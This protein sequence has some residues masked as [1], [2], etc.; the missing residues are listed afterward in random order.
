M[1]N[2]REMLRGSASYD[3]D[4][5]ARAEVWSNRADFDKRVKDFGAHAAT[6]AQLVSQ[7][8]GN[9]DAFKNAARAVAQDCKGCH[10][11]YQSK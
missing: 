1:K 2:A 11:T 6:L 9:T 4:T 3:G 8:G 10:D 5:Q 7:G